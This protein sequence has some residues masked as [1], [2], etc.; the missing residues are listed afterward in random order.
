MSE[1][2]ITKLLIELHYYLETNNLMDI[3][4]DPNR[5]F[6]G[7]ESDFSLYPTTGTVFGPKGFIHIQ[8]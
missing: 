8:I 7:D 3:F 2:S 4:D 1:E 5:I 6:S